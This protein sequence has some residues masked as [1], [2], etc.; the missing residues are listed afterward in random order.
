MGYGSDTVVRLREVYA[1]YITSDKWIIEN[2]SLEI[3]KGETVVLMGPSGCGKSTLLN[4]ISGL[5]PGVIPGHVKGEVFVDGVDPV[6]QGY[7]ALTGK[8]GIVYQNPE[9]QIITRSVFEELA[10]APEN[11]GLS[12]DE[13][14]ARVE[15]ALDALGLRGYEQKDPQ[16]L[17]GGEK[18]LLAIASVLTMKPKILL[19]DEPTSMLDH[20]GTQMVLTAIS[21]LKEEYGL[22]IIVA[23]HR[24]E[25]AVNV[26]DKIYLMDEGKILLGGTPQEVFSQMDLVTKLG[27][28][29]PGVAEIAY[30]LM[31]KGVRVKIP[32]RLEDFKELS[33]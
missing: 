18:Q 1:K 2:V 4:I 26:A 9:I 16:T 8:V 6:K 33:W 13:V 5:L 27:V 25:W 11:L 23:E 22:T 15:W 3:S 24:V 20:L 30:Q 31:K 32:V 28:R 29:P 21:R 7:K 19:L 12:K 14:L 17:S 10:M